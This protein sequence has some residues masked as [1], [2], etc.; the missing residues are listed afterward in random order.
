MEQEL[1]VWEVVQPISLGLYAFLPN[2]VDLVIPAP[3]PPPFTDS[4]G[5]FDD[6]M[7]PLPPPADYDTTGPTDFLEKGMIVLHAYSPMDKLLNA[8]MAQ[9]AC[10]TYSMSDQVIPLKFGLCL[11]CVLVVSLQFTFPPSGGAVQLQLRE[12]WRPGVPGGRSHLPDQ[13]E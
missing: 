2:P 5:G 11:C 8:V 1:L 10:S 7:P 3:P 9:I 12:S 6:V 13:E 4:V